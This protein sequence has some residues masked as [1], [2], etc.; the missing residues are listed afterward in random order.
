[1]YRRDLVNRQ[2]GQFLEP[3]RMNGQ[4]VLGAVM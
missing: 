3:R 1:M 2:V 4:T